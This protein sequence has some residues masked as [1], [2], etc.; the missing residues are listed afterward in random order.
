MRIAITGSSGLLGTA[1]VVRLRQDGDNI[2]RIVRSGEEQDWDSPVIMWNIENKQIEKE[3]LEGLDAIIHLAGA[4]I[5]AQ[6]WT[7]KYKKIMWDSRVQSAALLT[8]TIQKLRYPPKAFV[9]ASAV[10][11]YGNH[12]AGISV[13][14]STPASDDFLASLCQAWE[15]ASNPL[16]TAGM[17]VV[18]LRMGMVLSVKGGGLAKMLPIFKMGLGGKLGSGKQIMSWVALDELCEA[19]VFVLKQTNMA[20]AVNMVSPHAVSNAEFTKIL[21]QVLNRPAVVPA[22]SIALRI[23]LG[24]M[25]NPLLLEGARVAPRRLQE[26]GFAFKY[27]GLKPALENIITNNI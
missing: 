1:L 12:S 23:F 7:R 24:Q 19:I 11:Y 27:A 16:S 9:S 10:G 6:R 14:E 25:A 5:A 3:R 15:A 2:I 20:G 17:R 13:N 4:N 22:P 8:E 18:R 26:A 21:G